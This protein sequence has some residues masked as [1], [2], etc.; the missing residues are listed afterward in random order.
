MNYKKTVPKPAVLWNQD[1]TA[2]MTMEEIKNVVFSAKGR[3]VINDLLV[4]ERELNQKQIQE[5]CERRLLEQEDKIFQMIGTQNFI[6]SIE[7]IE[8][9]Y[10]NAGEER[11]VKFTIRQLQDAFAKCAEKNTGYRK[12][13]LSYAEVESELKKRADTSKKLSVKDVIRGFIDACRTTDTKKDE[14]AGE[15]VEH[16]IDY[17]ELSKAIERIN[18]EYGKNIQFVSTTM[19]ELLGLEHLTPWEDDSI[20]QN[21]TAWEIYE[22]GIKNAEIAVTA[23]CDINWIN[24]LEQSGKISGNMMK[25]IIRTVE[26]GKDDEERDMQ[27]MKRVLDRLDKYGYV[28]P[29]NHLL[30]IGKYI[31]YEL[32]YRNRWIWDRKEGERQ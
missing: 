13:Y 18:Q 29:K 22:L 28:I 7:K 21:M 24:A 27:K 11:N 8:E 23:F 1:P 30:T 31:K 20:F 19:N 26:N 15:P 14:A 5:S 12:K 9:V 4:R 17:S 16:E 6:C 10:R 25:S 32:V 3:I 2:G